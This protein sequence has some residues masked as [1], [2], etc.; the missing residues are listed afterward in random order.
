MV[1]S[2]RLR[3]RIAQ[4][5]GRA[6]AANPISVTLCFHPI[7]VS[8]Y[9]PPDST[10]T[11]NQGTYR[12]GIPRSSSPR[13]PADVDGLPKCQSSPYAARQKPTPPPWSCSHLSPRGVSR[14]H[15]SCRSLTGKA[16]MRM[17]RVVR[18]RFACC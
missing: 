11:M 18:R 3:L 9:P 2:K 13:Q 4:N 6:T 16:E 14:S 1:E 7:H 10:D 12:A 5:Q 15:D 8:T 17:G